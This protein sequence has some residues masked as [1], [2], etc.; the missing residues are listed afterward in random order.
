MGVVGIE[1]SDREAGGQGVKA[2]VGMGCGWEWLVFGKQCL[3]GE[4][5][6]TMEGDACWIRPRVIEKVRMTQ[7]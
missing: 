5:E 3:L 6:G 2:R 7:V 1:N 4:L